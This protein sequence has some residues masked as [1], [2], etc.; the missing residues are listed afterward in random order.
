M[1]L[2]AGYKQVT[3]TFRVTNLIPR[4]Q[5]LLPRLHSH[6]YNPGYKPYISDYKPYKQ[7]TNLTRLQTWLT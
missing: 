2:S 4:L 5:T 3:N 7:V 6:P 1:H